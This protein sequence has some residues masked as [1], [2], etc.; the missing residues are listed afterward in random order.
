MRHGRAFDEEPVALE[1]DEAG[2]LAADPAFVPGGIDLGDHLAVRNP[3]AAGIGDHCA[4]RLG[5]LFIGLGN[6][7]A[8]GGDEREPYPIR[9]R[10]LT[11]PRM[12]AVDGRARLALLV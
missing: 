11:A 3:V 5:A 1:P 10:D 9:G 4:Q 12:L 8:L 2:L 6:G 7:P